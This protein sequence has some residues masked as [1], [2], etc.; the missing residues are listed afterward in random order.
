MN[1]PESAALIASLVAA[2]PAARF[3]VE[4][5]EMY[6]SGISDL[7]AQ[8]TQA[9][10][11]EL[12]HSE[13]FLPS[14]AAIRAEVMRA[15]RARENATSSARNLLKARDV[16]GRPIGP[17]PGAWA[18]KLVGMAEEAKRHAALSRAWYTA[19][20][21]PAPRDPGTEYLELVSAGAN[22]ADVRDRFRETVAP[23]LDDSERRYP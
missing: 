3:S 4:N 15:R 16:T 23:G 6:E 17:Q 22:G 21:K 1:K 14:I 9:A 18:A 19:R 8:E 2:F 12:I 7:G 5:A 13:K 20:G 11:G 10:I